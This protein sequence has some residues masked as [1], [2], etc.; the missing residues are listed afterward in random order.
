MATEVGNSTDTMSTAEKPDVRNWFGD[1]SWDASAL[2]EAR[3]VED[4]VAV[5]RDADKYPS[6]V[7]GRGSGHSTTICGVADGGTVVDVTA[8]NRIVEIG[9]DTV[10][11]EAGA[12][13]IDV[14]QELQKRNLQ[15]YVNIE[16]GNATMGSLATCATKDASMPGEFGQV[17]SYC[18]GMKLV[19]PSGEILEVDEKD[20]DLLRAARS[21]FGL[22]GIAYEVTFKVRPLQA[23]AVEHK[24]FKVDDYARKLPELFERGQ[25]IMMYIFP[26]LD[27]VGVEF[28]RYTGPADQAAEPATHRLWKLRNFAWKTFM[29]G[30]GALTERWVPSRGARYR[31]INGLNRTTKAV[32]LPRLSAAN[33]V[34]ME[35]TIRYPKVSGGSRYTFSIWAF[36]EAQYGDTLLAYFK[37]AKE[38]AKKTGFRPNMLHVGYRI[39]QDDSSLF[40]Y[41]F[42]S[43][44]LTIDPVSTGAPG[45]KE[46]LK[47]YN[48]FCSDH[49]GK[50]LFNQSWGLTHEQVRKAFGDRIDEFEGHRK[51]YDPNDRLLNSYFR[52][53]FQGT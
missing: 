33:T 42:H 46:F 49:D 53:L 38:Y 31:M 16:L 12:L 51:R 8:M 28:R 34:P 6:P 21:S 36:P 23:M 25:S 7:R 27:S 14:S 22:F 17:N 29:P 3:S 13:L 5:M 37:W 40:S 19:L 15:M 39:M 11:A 2:V 26:Y 45:W 32:M 50:P 30:F 4:I 47:E 52:E 35:Q 10:T 20:P 1:L 24:V 9:E 43:N 41:T 18:I 48:Q 44:V